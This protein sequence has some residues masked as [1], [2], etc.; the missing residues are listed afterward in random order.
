MLV[1]DRLAAYAA[2]STKMLYQ[3]AMSPVVVTSC[4]CEAFMLALSSPRWS[5]L[6]HAY[7]AASDIPPLLEQLEAEPNR[8]HTDCRDEPWFS[9]W[10]SLCHQGDVYSASYAT[11]AHLIRIAASIPDVPVVN[12]FVLPTSIEVARLLGYGPPPPPD[13]AAD[14]SSALQQLHDLAYRLASIA[15]DEVLSRAI[16][17]ALVVTKGYAFLADTIL[18]LSPEAIKEFRVARGLDTTDYSA[19]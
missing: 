10:S 5:E 19:T 18:E 14:Y 16:A 8:V 7:G 15:W 11:V 13:L 3:T 4:D 2:R 12:Y 17:A 6:R 1:V 9:L